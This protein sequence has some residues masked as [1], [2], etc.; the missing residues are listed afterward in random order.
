MAP[1]QWCVPNLLFPCWLI[2]ND[3]QYAMITEAYTCKYTHWS[4]QNMTLH[5]VIFLCVFSSTIRFYHSSD[6]DKPMASISFKLTTILYLQYIPRNMHMVFALLC[7]VVVI[8]WLIF[9]YPPGL[10]R[11]HCGNLTIAPV[12]AKQPWWI[13]INTSREIIMRDYITTTKQSTTKPCAYLLGYTAY[14]ND[15]SGLLVQ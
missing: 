5:F 13:W 11:W 14:H 12:P 4:T 9:P 10:L 7:F 6:Y 1:W 15:I 8:H 3:V 2:F